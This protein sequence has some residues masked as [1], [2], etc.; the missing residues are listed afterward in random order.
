MVDVQWGKMTVETNKMEERTGWISL[1]FEQE[2]VE[3]CRLKRNRITLLSY[4][5][6]V[7]SGSNRRPPEKV[8]I[9]LYGIPLHAWNIGVLILV[10]GCVGMETWYWEVEN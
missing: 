8:W 4:F 5:L 3:I 7:K 1:T 2:L 6:K 10:G 9:C